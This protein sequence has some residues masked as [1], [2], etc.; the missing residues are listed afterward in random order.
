MCNVV[1]IVVCPFV[2][3]PLAIA[4][5]VLRYT[6]SDYTFV[7]FK[8]FLS[9]ILPDLF[10]N[11]HQYRTR[12]A[13]YFISVPSRTTFY[14]NCCL[15]ST[16]RLWNNYSPNNKHGISIASRNRFILVKTTTIPTLN[17]TDPSSY[18]NPY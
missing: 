14:F 2:L 17:R 6:D 7:I 12:Q 10:R 1:Q 9:S 11:I 5:S 15:P 16:V 13:N 4:L 3:F 8:L 18:T